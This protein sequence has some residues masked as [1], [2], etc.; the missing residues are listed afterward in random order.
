MVWG[1]NS[2]KTLEYIGGECDNSS[3]FFVEG[4]N[5]P[6]SAANSGGST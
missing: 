5:E 1:E 3:L 6:H 2:Q 4:R